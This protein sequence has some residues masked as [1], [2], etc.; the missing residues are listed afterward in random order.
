M[1]PARRAVIS[2]A[3]SLAVTAGAA[4]I[5]TGKALLD[6][7][8]DPKP[9]GPAICSAGVAGPTMQISRR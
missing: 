3:L 8:D 7:L 4:P 2:A 6:T 1:A 5:N 9:P